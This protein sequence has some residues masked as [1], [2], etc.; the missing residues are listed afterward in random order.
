MNFMREK[1]IINNKSYFDRKRNVK[2]KLVY[3]YKDK[4]WRFVMTI[5]ISDCLYSQKLEAFLENSGLY[6]T[7]WP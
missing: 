7:R 2:V 5:V 1:K 3:R 6:K 4:N